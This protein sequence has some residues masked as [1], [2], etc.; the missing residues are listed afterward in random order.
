MIQRVSNTYEIRTI[1][2]L[3]AGSRAHSLHAQ[4]KQK[5]CGCVVFRRLLYLAKVDSAY[6]TYKII[7]TIMNNYLCALVRAK[8]KKNVWLLFV[9]GPDGH[10]KSHE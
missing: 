5:L 4:Q 2:V 1:I 8:I 3:L 10:H 7:R 9:G 6:D